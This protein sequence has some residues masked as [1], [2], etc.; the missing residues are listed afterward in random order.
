M[1]RIG[2]GSQLAPQSSVAGAPPIRK[3]RSA[4]ALNAMS[5]DVVVPTQTPTPPPPPAAIV[6]AANASLEN[7]ATCFATHGFPN[8]VF[9]RDTETSRELTSCVL[10]QEKPH[11]V[12]AIE[13][14]VAYAQRNA[15]FDRWIA[16]LY[17]KRKR[18]RKTKFL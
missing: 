1:R 16:A 7:V 2:S 8:E 10:A 18:E 4:T 15:R 13:D 3:V 6:L 11:S 9:D 14:Q 12:P 5:S 17:E